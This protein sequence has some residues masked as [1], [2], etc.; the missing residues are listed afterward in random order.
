[1]FLLTYLNTYALEHIF[2]RETPAQRLRVAGP[3][4][5]SSNTRR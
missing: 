3:F 2:Y 5:G 4:T 1:M